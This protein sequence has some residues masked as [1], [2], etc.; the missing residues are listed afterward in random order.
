MSSGAAYRFSI[1]CGARE[2]TEALGSADSKGSQIPR[3]NVVRWRGGY[4][5][6]RLDQHVAGIGEA[7]LGQMA[8]DQVGHPL[9]KAVK[10]AVSAPYETGSSA[11]PAAG[12]DPA[13]TVTNTG[14]HLAAVKRDVQVSVASRFVDDEKAKALVAAVLQ[15]T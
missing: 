9:P 12:A 1:S 4:S 6:W 8:E 15:K 3:P 7:A 2:K 5:E 11:A 14:L 13:E 10:E